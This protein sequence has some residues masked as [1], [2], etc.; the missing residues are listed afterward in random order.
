[1][2]MLPLCLVHEV[3]GLQEHEDAIVSTA[4]TWLRQFATLNLQKLNLGVLSRR[5][6]L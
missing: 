1:M 6:G 2:V 3:I 4:M 5:H